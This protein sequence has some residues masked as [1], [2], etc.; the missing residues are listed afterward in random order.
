MSSES[1][2]GNISVIELVGV[3]TISPE[4]DEMGIPHRFGIQKHSLNFLSLSAISLSLTR[5]VRKSDWTLVRICH[6]FHRTISV[7]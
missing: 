2:S 6:S 7:R 1:D 4:D 5:M 3:S